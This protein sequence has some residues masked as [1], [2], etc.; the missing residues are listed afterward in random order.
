MS[1][2]RVAALQLALG[3][4]VN[5]NIGRAGQLVAEAA[6]QGA[7]IALLP[8]LFASRY[9]PARPDP[10]SFALAAPPE[11]SPAVQAMRVLA[12]TH[13]LVLPVSYF[14]R[15][16][17]RFFNSLIVFDADGR[18]VGRYR[19]SHIPDGPGY[20]EKQFF[21]PGDSGFTVFDTR[22]GRLG[23]GICWDQWFPECARALALQGA[24]LLL[25]PTAIGSE[26]TRPELDTQ[27]PWQ[28]V[29]IGHAVANTVPLVAANRVGDEM[30][31]IFY[32]S[33]FIVDGR[34]EKLAELDRNSQGVALADIDL[35]SWHQE[36]EWFGLLRD[37]RPEMYTK[38][39]QR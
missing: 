9:F 25:Y 27:G 21:A 32:G 10:S 38:L 28:R 23:I 35:D 37:R 12:A 34:G 26:P 33:S 13:E 36:R 24:D 1:N 8:E 20:E 11:S 18:E 39:T 16:G 2:I 7:Q 30:G 5:E 14:E 29:M 6:A 17:D 31:Q 4:D 22:Y 15:D 3:D 19:K